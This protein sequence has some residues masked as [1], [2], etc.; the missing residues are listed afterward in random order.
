MEPGEVRILVVDDEDPVRQAACRA[1]KNAGHVADE[2][3]DGRTALAMLRRSPYDA[4]VTD[5]R[6]P[7]AGGEVLL[8]EAFTHFPGTAVLVMAGPADIPS[9]V[10]AVR[11][12]ARDYIPKPFHP[13]ELV[14]RVE[15]GLADRRLE[16]ENLR[17]RGELEERQRFTGLVGGSAPMQDICS[18]VRLV[19][20]K[21]G[22]VLVEGEPGTGKKLIARLLHTNSPRKDRPLVSLD[23]GALP[24]ALL[25][26]ELSARLTEAR[27][28]TLLLEE[29]SRM[30]G[31]LQAGLLRV[32]RE[33]EPGRAGGSSTVPADVRII[34]ATSVDLAS[35]VQ[36]GGFRSD[37]YDLLGVLP[38]RVPPL[39][40]RRDDIPPLVA[41]FVR[42]FCAGQALPPKQVSH[43]AMRRLMAHD[44]PG[45]VRQL[46][47][48]VE[49]AVALS[50]GRPQLD[51]GDFPLLSGPTE[52]DPGRGEIEIPQDGVH[53]NAVISDLEK[54]LILRSLEAT[55]GNKKRAASLLHLK[56]TTFVEKLRK[57]ETGGEPPHEAGD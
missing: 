29:V 38:I 28:G 45:N 43:D 31:E 50:A 22:A 2:A 12:G 1:L 39:R 55:R 33:R 35:A 27:G 32:L 56:R 21:S 30:P 51:P 4:I 20:P 36:E 18:L 54:R 9:A 44:W 3:A 48:A 25:E 10:E 49:T 5:L 57:L 46:E 14:L 23:C 17:M 13:A 26:G 41:H 15:K 42:K 52:P 47:N 34:A 6:L 8:E 40:R 16:R 53:F 37:L 11:R 19:A 24:P 7:G